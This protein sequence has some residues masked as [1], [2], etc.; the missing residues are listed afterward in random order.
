MAERTFYGGVFQL[1]GGTEKDLSGPI[2]L[3]DLGA[4]YDYWGATVDGWII[5]FYDQSG[6]DGSSYQVAVFA[7][8]YEGDLEYRLETT[9]SDNIVL[10][11]HFAPVGTWDQYPDSVTIGEPAGPLAIKLI[12]D[13]GVHKIALCNCPAHEGLAI[14]LTR[15]PL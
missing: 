5:E 1:Q 8:E 2:T 4:P 7:P 15:A 12:N 11:F 9:E 10:P 14:K 13:G 6:G 3:I